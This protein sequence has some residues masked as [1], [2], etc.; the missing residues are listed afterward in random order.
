MKTLAGLLVVCWLAGSPAGAEVTILRGSGATLPYPLYQQW[1]EVYPR[2]L[3]RLSYDPVGSG[4][5]IQALLHDEVD[6]GATDAFLTDRELKKAGGN[7]LHIPTC[8]GAV[9]I[10]CNLPGNPELRLTSELIAGIFMGKI[11]RWSDYRIG[12]VNPEVALPDLEIIVI[13]RSDGSGT[14]FIFTDFLAKTNQIWD[15]YL[16]RGR[17][18]R[19]PT[20]L[21]LNGNAGVVQYIKKIAGSIG[22]VELS[23]TRQH[24]LPAALVRNRAGQLV[25]PGPSSALALA[26]M[27]FPEDLRLSLTDPP[28]EEAYPIIGFS[29]L[30]VRQEQA[31]ADRTRERALALTRFLW[32]AV[33]EGQVYNEGLL[34]G[35]LPQ[36]VVQK[37]E[38]LIRSLRYEGQPLMNW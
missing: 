31:Y 20:G 18:M 2:E 33:H 1:I 37:A 11:T 12:A 15:D 4:K 23:Y 24:N 27:E 35:T 26:G 14:T 25:R 7:I 38:A 34:Y 21:G 29:Y 8:I 16:G 22:Y 13:Y 9:A 30:I 5:G 3:G 32:W 10:A 36:P 6:F 28:S 19:W 17:Q